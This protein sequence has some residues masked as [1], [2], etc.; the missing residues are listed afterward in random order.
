MWVVSYSQK[1]PNSWG[2]CIKAFNPMPVHTAHATKVVD[3]LELTEQ[4]WSTQI[5]FLHSH[6][7]L[8]SYTS[9]RTHKHTSVPITTDEAGKGAGHDLLVEQ[10]KRIALDF[11]LV[12]FPF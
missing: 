8:S 11:L 10:I 12:P 3:I 1:A 6:P 2:A 9:I 4:A 7:T 5:R